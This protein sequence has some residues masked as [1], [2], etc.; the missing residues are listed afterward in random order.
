MFPF[1]PS[2]SNG[3]TECHRWHVVT[4]VSSLRYR[5]RSRSHDRVVRPPPSDM[6]CSR[7]WRGRGLLVAEKPIP[8]WNMVKWPQMVFK[9]GRHHIKPVYRMEEKHNC[10]QSCWFKGNVWL[11]KTI[12]RCLR[13][14]ATMCHNQMNIKRKDPP[15]DSDLAVVL[16]AKDKFHQ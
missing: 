3:P 7:G 9:H 10:I 16:Y 15:T 2:M 11:I 14:G 13:G 12:D 6:D 8:C 5:D 1:I 4:Y